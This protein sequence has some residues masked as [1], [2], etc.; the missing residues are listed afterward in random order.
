M[1]NEMKFMYLYENYLQTMDVMTHEQFY[2]FIRLIRNYMFYDID[3]NVDDIYDDMVKLAWI[4]VSTN[5]YSSKE[6]QLKSIY[7]KSNKCNNN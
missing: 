5:L 7:Q 2:E 3:V 6:Q 1:R 4:G